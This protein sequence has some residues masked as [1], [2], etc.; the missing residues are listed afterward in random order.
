VAQAMSK[1]DMSTVTSRSQV[2][3]IL[4]RNIDDELVVGFLLQN[5]TRDIH[6]H[7]SWTLNLDV[8]NRDIELVGE[9]PET[10]ASYCHPTVL[11]T[12]EES[13]HDLVD[14]VSMKKLFPLMRQVK[15]KQ[16]GH[17][18]HADAPE[19]VTEALRHFVAET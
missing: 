19:V 9:W 8:L 4:A 1:V 17:W 14:Q 3:Q 11:I 5:L 6:H 15:V 16:A 12:G 7:W 10:S 13:D 18:V 2:R